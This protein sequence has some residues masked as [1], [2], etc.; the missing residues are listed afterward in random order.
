MPF[1]QELSLMRDDQEPTFTQKA[2]LF[3]SDSP[4]LQMHHKQN[5]PLQMSQGKVHCPHAI[6]ANIHLL[7]IS[8][9]INWKKWK[10]KQPIEHTNKQT[11][12]LSRSM[13][14]KLAFHKHTICQGKEIFPI[15]KKKWQ[16]IQQMHLQPKQI[17]ILSKL[18]LIF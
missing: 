3:V 9:T 6:L 1:V 11:F 4:L 16:N 18:I 5:I 2:N 14:F 8:N 15:N 12:K 17:V 10:N 7:T 13:I